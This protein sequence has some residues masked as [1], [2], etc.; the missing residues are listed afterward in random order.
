MFEQSPSLIQFGFYL[1]CLVF[2]GFVFLCH[3]GVDKQ[4]MY[5]SL[6]H[7]DLSRSAAGAVPQPVFVKPDILCSF[8]EVVFR[9]VFFSDFHQL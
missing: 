2:L 5:I 7:E 3:A 1:S 6:A 8:K 9:L 4:C